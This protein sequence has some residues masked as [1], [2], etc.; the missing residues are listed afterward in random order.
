MSKNDPNNMND[1]NLVK[2]LA[3]AF[4]IYLSDRKLRELRVNYEQE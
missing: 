1:Y 2:Q 3:E 4:E